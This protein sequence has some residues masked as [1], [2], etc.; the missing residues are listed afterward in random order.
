[1]RDGAFGMS[2]GLFYVPGDFTP[3]E[4]V[5]EL[6]E[7]RRAS[8]G[9]IHTSHMRDE[10]SRRARQRE[11]NHRDRRAG[12]CADAGH[13]SQDCR[14][15]ELGKSVETL[16]LI[17]EARARGV[18]ATIDQYPYTASSTNIAAALIPQWAQEGGREQ[19]LAAAEGPC[20]AR[21]DQG[22]DRAESSANERGGG[23]PKQCRAFAQC[24]FDP[25]LAGKNLRRRHAKRAA[26]S[27]RSRT[28]RKR[29]CGSSSR[30]TA[31]A[32]STR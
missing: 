25:A 18:D 19:M 4:E 22:R 26:W 27:R 24:D 9:G 8:F 17:D 21:E 1:M 10:A 15:G 7:G 2:T 11:R 31:R 32:S 14:Q 6:A 29:R 16:K 3:I 28:R 13:A 30:A 23:D 20:Y 5:I 12:R